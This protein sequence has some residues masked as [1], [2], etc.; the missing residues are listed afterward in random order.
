MT[1]YVIVGLV[2]RNS[3][4]EF[5]AI[6][7]MMR[8]QWDKIAPEFLL[9]AKNTALTIKE[10]YL[11]PIRRQLGSHGRVTTN[12]CENLNARFQQHLNHQRLPPHKMIRMLDSFIDG[13]LFVLSACIFYFRYLINR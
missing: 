1:F 7:T 6:F 10:S 2:D 8:Q 4:E 5:D 12:D 3:K 9:F 13:I 11:A